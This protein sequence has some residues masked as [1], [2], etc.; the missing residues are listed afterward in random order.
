MNDEGLNTYR[1]HSCGPLRMRP[2][3]APPD[4]SMYHTSEV[5]L[6]RLCEPAIFSLQIFALRNGLHHLN[7]S[8]VIKCNIGSFYKFMRVCCASISVNIWM[9]DG[10]ISKIINKLLIIRECISSIK[11]DKIFLVLVL[12][13]NFLKYKHDLIREDK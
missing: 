3:K 6:S 2:H 8:T 4:R 10:I 1:R 11:K 9:E 12:L 13:Q 7:C 5:Y